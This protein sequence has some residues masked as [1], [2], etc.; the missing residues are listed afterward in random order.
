M[1]CRTSLSHSEYWQCDVEHLFLIQSIG[2]VCRHQSLEISHSEYWQC[3][4]TPIPGDI[5]FRVLAMCVDTNPWRY[6]IQSI[7]NVCRHQSLEISHSEYW[8]C[9]ST[10]IPGDISFRVLAMFV[11]TNP[12]RYH[13]FDQCQSSKSVIS[14]LWILA[15]TTL[16]SCRNNLTYSFDDIW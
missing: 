3:L 10:P 12:W 2:N 7:G 6:L 1:W 5:S 11:D 4:S 14:L 16:Q 15:Q 9:V 13:V 8:Q